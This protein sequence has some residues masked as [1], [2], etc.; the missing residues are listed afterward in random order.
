MLKLPQ[1]LQTIQDVVVQAQPTLW[2]DF[3]G[4]NHA[5]GYCQMPSGSQNVE[6]NY[7]GNQGR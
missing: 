3:C 6:V 7:M 5:N 4:H 1:Q 2:C